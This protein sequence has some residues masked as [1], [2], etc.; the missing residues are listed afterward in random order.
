MP[1]SSH[2]HRHPRP[3]TPSPKLSSLSVL[4]DL[5]KGQIA[6]TARVRGIPQEAVIND[7]LLA[8][9]PTKQF[10]DPKVSL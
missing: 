1:L 10:V 6:D 8:D 2:W 7:V 9:Q 4:T 3:C 5:V